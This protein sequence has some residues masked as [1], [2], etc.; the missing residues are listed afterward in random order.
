M[1]IAD[2]GRRK[3]T[4]RLPKLFDLADDGIEVG[5]VAGIELGMEQFTIG[6]N[7]E[8]AAARGNERERPDTFAEFKNLGRQTDGL[9][10]VVSNDAVFDGDFR[11]H[12]VSSFP[13]NMVGKAAEWVKVRAAPAFNERLRVKT[14]FGEAYKAKA[15][16]E[17]PATAILTHSN[18]AGKRKEVSLQDC[19]LCQL[20]FSNLLGKD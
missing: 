10:R 7:L 14:T 18:C 6:A 4:A 8:S 12:P 19:N 15:A 16:A 2:R 11:L 5:P 9:G 1:W 13:R 3:K 20:Q 17:L